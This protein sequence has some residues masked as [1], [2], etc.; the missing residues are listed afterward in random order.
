[1]GLDEKEKEVDP[2]DEVFDVMT[3]RR[4]VKMERH[5]YF[6][7]CAEIEKERVAASSAA[8]EAM[9]MILRLQSDKSSTEIQANQFRR[10]VEERQE[11]D[12]EVIESLRWDVLQLENQKSFLEHDLGVYKEKLRQ[13]M[14]DDEIELIEGADFTREF[15]NF[16]VEYD[17]DDSHSL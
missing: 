10:M 9:A 12:Q 11:Y 7:A 13:F 4:M 5:K 6:S 14:R 3:L 8:E 2:E 15:C 16:S 1:V 17:V